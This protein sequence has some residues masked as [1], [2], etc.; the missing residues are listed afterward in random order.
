MSD[1]VVTCPQCG[2]TFPLSE[3]L[4]AQLHAR[5]EADHQAR[6]TAAVREAGAIRL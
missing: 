1:M 2:H 6:L 5:F 4:A 3:A